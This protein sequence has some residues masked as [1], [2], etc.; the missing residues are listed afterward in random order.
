[1]K[2]ILTAIILVP[3]AVL[4][5]FLGP[6]W[7]V[8]LF[9]AVVAMLAGWEFLH[10]AS[11]SA[12]RPPQIAALVAIALLFMMN[13]FWPEILIGSISLLSL[14]LLVWCAFAS[15]LER[16]MADA[17]ASV[18]ALLYT[19]L[20]MLAL[21]LLYTSE[22]GKSIVLFLLCCVWTGDIA[23]LYVGRTFGRHRLA[24][25]I[26][27]NKTWEGAVGSLVGSLAAAALLY[28]LAA[29]LNGRDINML[30]YPGPLLRW[31]SL[32]LLVN[33]AAQVGDLVESALKRSVG[34]KDSGT[35]LPGHGGM[36]DRVDALLLAAP[37]LWYAQVIQRF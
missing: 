7:M 3:L 35:L 27:P 9:A 18:F 29:L 16:V 33:V 30:L 12:A 36:L 1:M 32:S 25:H 24:P 10:I 22:D 34:V 37:V 31:L 15:P 14:G 26:S 2:R 28:G 6:Y 11:A 8:T 13:Y 4:T 23:A 5:L 19:G 17:T 21:P 20:T